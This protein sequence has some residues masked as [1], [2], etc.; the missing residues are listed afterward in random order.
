M[1]ARQSNHEGQL[2]DWLHE[3]WD[4]E[5]AGVVVNAGALTHYSIALRDAISAIGPPVIEL[6][7]SNIHAREDFRHVSVIAP[8]TLGMIW[9]SASTAMSSPSAR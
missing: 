2:V 7:I 8:V 1:D 3:A 5:A 4:D 6:H 9:A